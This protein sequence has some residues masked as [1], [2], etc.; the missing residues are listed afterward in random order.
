MSD[1]YDSMMVSASG[2]R[3]QSLRM[4]VVAENL[5]NANSIGVSP[6]EDPYRRKTISFQETLDRQTGVA[7]VKVAEVAED[8]SDFRLRYEPGHPAANAQGYV[9]LP[10]VEPM[11]ESMDMR[12]A[13]RAYEANLTVIETA[14]KMLARTVDLLKT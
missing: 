7:T 8:T 6:D 1:L 11:V 5:A 12:E 10:N 13:Q 14:R 4:R 2:L 9:R 3:A